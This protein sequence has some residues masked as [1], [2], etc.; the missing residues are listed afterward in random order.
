MVFWGCKSGPKND[1]IDFPVI[2][3]A[4]LFETE[5]PN[6][7]A[8]PQNL[9][10]LDDHVIIYDAM[11]DWVFKV[12]FREDFEFKGQF[13]RRG[14][15]PLE[16]VFVS[17][18]FRGSGDNTL[19][20]QTTSAVKVARIQEG[21]NGIDLLVLNEHALP[22]NMLG[23]SEFF[24]LNDKVCSS[25]SFLPSEKDFRCYDLEGDST[26]EWG[27][28]QAI[29]KPANFPPD[30]VFYLAKYASLH[31]DGKLLAVVYQNLP[32]L[33]IYCTQ[34]G[35][36]LH[37]LHMA[38]SSENEELIQR[39]FFETGFITYYWQLKSTNEFIYGLFPGA[40]L[41]FEDEKIPDFASVIHIWDWNGN[42]IMNLKFER[43]V[44]SFD[45]TPDNKQIIALS[46]VDVDKLFV[47]EI[48]WD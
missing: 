7:L 27:E 36:I 14:R 42:P 2:K 19:L 43:S 26:I 48:P 31:P 6:L 34:T 39:N 32:I 16:E 10:I 8:M 13:I 3:S 25:I 15:G 1:I 28:F 29:S 11:T 5:I 18:L 9:V 24:L 41:S 45:V 30:A 22:A 23:D 37:Q 12:F 40:E 4:S 44:F 33:R 17:H 47:S 21:T 35:Q 38:N 20:F 46:I